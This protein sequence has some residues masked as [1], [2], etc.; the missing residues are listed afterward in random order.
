MP[1]YQVASAPH[2]T[3]AAVMDVEGAYRT[4]P[5][6]PDHKRFIIVRFKNKYYI[7]HNVPFGAGSAHGLQGEVA[8]ATVDIF[9]SLYIH[10]VIKWVD[11]FN[12]FRFPSTSRT[13]SSSEFPSLR[14][15]Y[16]LN[17]VKFVIAPLRIPWHREKGQDFH[18]IFPYLGFMWNLSDKTV[19]IPE[20]KCSKHYSRLL[21]FLS[22]CRDHKVLKKDAQKISGS[23]SHL[24]FVLQRGRSFLANLFH[25]IGTFPNEFAPRYPPPSVITD[26]TWWLRAL[27]NTSPVRRLY[28]PTDPID[29]DIWVDAST[30]WGIGITAK[31]K[32]DAWRTVEGWQGPGHDIGWLEAMAIEFLIGTLVSNDLKD[33]HILIRSDNQ[34]VMGAFTKGHSRNFEVNLAIRRTEALIDGANISLSFQYVE[35]AFNLAD[36]ISRGILPLH[37]HRLPS[38]FVPNHNIAR[39]FTHA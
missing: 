29:L 37:V 2:G 19:T 9:Y 31:G 17:Y 39:F 6:K 36:P 38:N 22:K 30:D 11:D 16:D 21:T 32:W 20:K 18:S 26:L 8:D 5:V 34:G 14:Y 1:P 23:L 33:S 12:I 28:P 3:Q 4:I 24:S 35:S 27:E 7:D 15:D 10:P 25:W 13:Y